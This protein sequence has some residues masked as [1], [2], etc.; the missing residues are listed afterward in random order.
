MG[1]AVRRKNEFTERL[2]PPAVGLDDV[3][4]CVV[5]SSLPRDGTNARVCY[6]VKC[7][8]GEFVDLVL[9]F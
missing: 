6:V 4:R 3:E 1:R 5:A 9:F 8:F 2:A 7:I